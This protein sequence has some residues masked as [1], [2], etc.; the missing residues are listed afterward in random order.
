MEKIEQT[1]SKLHVKLQLL[2]ES[3]S[4]YE[5]TLKSDEFINELAN[6]LNT[7]NALTELYKIVKEGNVCL[8]SNPININQLK[9]VYFTLK[10]ML[11]LLGLEYDLVTLTDEDKK[12]FEEYNISKANKDFTKSDELRKILIER[13]II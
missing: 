10:D 3:V 8:R 2:N 4:N 13:K 12:L 9:E 1:F 6:D 5:G 11:Y 7:P